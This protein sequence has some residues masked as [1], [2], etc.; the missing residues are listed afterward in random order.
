[1]ILFFWSIFSSCELVRPKIEY[2]E[3][4]LAKMK[5]GDESKKDEQSDAKDETSLE[6]E[7]N[8]HHHHHNYPH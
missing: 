3:K 2:H 1:M 6:Q 7:N 8:R 5:E 4:K